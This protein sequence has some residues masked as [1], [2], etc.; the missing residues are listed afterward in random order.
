M[1]DDSASRRRRHTAA[2]AQAYRT[3]HEIMSAALSIAIFAGI[4]YW[5]DGRL[6]WRPVLTICGSVLGM[7]TAGVSL[8][9]LLVRLDSESKLQKQQ[10]VSRGTRD[11]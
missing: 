3:S 8:R 2:I 10:S 6:N 11:E 7:M 4:G 1:E 9:R 5:L